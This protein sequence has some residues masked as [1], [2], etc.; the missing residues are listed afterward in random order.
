MRFNIYLAIISTATSASS[1]SGSGAGENPSR[2][3]L[4][5]PAFTGNLSI[6][7]NSYVDVQIGQM[8]LQFCPEFIG[9]PKQSCQDCGG[10]T[11]VKGFCDNVSKQ[12]T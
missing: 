7:N 2:R 5:T 4:Q 11:K 6:A 8:L 1:F 12:P 9:K 10:D 3:N